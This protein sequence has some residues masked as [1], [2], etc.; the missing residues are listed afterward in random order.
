MKETTIAS[1]KTLI[2]L[3]ENSSLT[4]LKVTKGSFSIELTRGAAVS[5]APSAPA[6]LPTPPAAKEGMITTITS[7]L[8]GTF[9]AAP[10]PDEPPFVQKGQHITEKDI[11][12]L[13]ESMKVFTEI[14]SPFSG[15]VE[16]ILVK[17]GDFV[18][19]DQPLFRI[20]QD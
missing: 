18:E 3:F 17:N 15:T 2:S 19:Y 10:S 7:P 9:Y 12:G 1:I 14:P 11:V 5:S 13:V 6:P 20:R 8:V 4:T 16:E